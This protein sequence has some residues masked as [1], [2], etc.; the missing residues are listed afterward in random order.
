MNKAFDAVLQTEVDVAVI[1]K[2]SYS[3][4]NG[5]FRLN[6]FVAVKKYTLQLLTVT[7]VLLTSDTEG[8]TMTQSVNDI[9]GAPAP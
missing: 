9:S 6:V 3:G 7:S 4:Y 2:T 5:R 8:E 1:A